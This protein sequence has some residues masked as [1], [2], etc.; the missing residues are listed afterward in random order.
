MRILRRLVYGKT[1]LKRFVR[2]A[3][4]AKDDADNEARMKNV[5]DG[6]QRE[7]RAGEYDFDDDTFDDDLYGQTTKRGEKRVKPNASMAELRKPCL[8]L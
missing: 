7:K 3:D 4:R 8:F 1:V 2:R 5:A 6:K